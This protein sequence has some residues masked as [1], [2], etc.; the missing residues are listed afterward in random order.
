M[1]KAAKT[2]SSYGTIRIDHF[3]PEKEAP[4]NALNIVLSFEEALKLHLGLLQILGKINQL[5][6]RFEEGNLA[7]V[8][9]CVYPTRITIN[10]AKIRKSPAKKAGPEA[11]SPSPMREALATYIAE[12]QATPLADLTKETY[13]LH[14]T[15][16]VRWTEGDFKPGS[17]KK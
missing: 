12:V 9:L 8:D 14:A 13:V 11:P 5:D 6:R 7:A 10:D 4:Q 1:A 17:A 3:S 2:K 15:N 16:F